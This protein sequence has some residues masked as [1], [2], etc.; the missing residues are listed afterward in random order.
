ME[1]KYHYASERM[2]GE[3]IAAYEHKTRTTP[4]VEKNRTKKMDGI[5]I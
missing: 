2:V 1:E 3:S 5:D 4:D